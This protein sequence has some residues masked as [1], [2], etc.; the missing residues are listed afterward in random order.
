MIEQG[1][2][3]DTGE[4]ERPRFDRIITQGGS[5]AKALLDM[6]LEEDWRKRGIPELSDTGGMDDGHGYL[7][8][9]IID[10]AAC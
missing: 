1:I 10:L 2:A 5:R 4:L 3:L 8:G 9:A 7:V 6:L